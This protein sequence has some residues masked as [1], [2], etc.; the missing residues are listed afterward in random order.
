MLPSGR[1]P[2]DVL[3]SIAESLQAESDLPATAEQVLTFA[4]ETLTFDYAGITVLNGGNGGNGNGGN[5]G[6]GG[7]GIATLV[8]SDPVV[9]KADELQVEL[10]EGPCR[11]AA[12]AQHTLIVEDLARDERWPRWAPQA[13]ALG[14][15]SILAVELGPQGGRFGALNLY[16]EGPRRF[17]EDEIAFAHVFGRH[18]AVALA[19]AR[20]EETLN[21]AID[22][23]TLIGQ[24]QGMLMERFDLNS[25]KA[26]EVLRRY[27]QDYNTKLRVVAEELVRTRK[28]PG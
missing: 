23:R 21:E 16:C 3:A 2:I 18:A 8:S 17:A 1:D 28:L 22:A 13:S 19:A 26:F 27:S 6:N 12:W 14:L 15:G 20:Q 25:D 11:D 24:A 4:Q 7:K 5:G 10:D 9:E